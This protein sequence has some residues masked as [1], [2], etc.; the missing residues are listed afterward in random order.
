MIRLNVRIDFAKSLNFT[1]GLFMVFSVLLRLSSAWFWLNEVVRTFISFLINTFLI[2]YGLLYFF[3]I[4]ANN[5]SCLVLFSYILSLSLDIFLVPLIFFHPIYTGTRLLIQLI[6]GFLLL[7]KT[8]RRSNSNVNSLIAFGVDEILVMLVTFFILALGIFQIVPKLATNVYVDSFNH[9]WQSVIL[10]RAPQAYEYYQYLTYHSLEVAIIDDIGVS[11][12]GMPNMQLVLSFLNFIPIIVLYELSN[13]VFERRH[14]KIALFV[15]LVFVFFSG[16]A[17][18]YFMHQQLHHPDWQVNYT[19]EL[20]KEKT[21]SL[22]SYGQLFFITGH[23]PAVSAYAFLMLMISLYFDKVHKERDVLLILFLSSFL[24]IFLHLP[25]YVF[26]SSF[27]S[28]YALLDIDSKNIRRVAICLTGGVV[29][30]ILFLFLSRVSISLIT[31]IALVTMLIIVIFKPVIPFGKHFIDFISNHLPIIANI[32][33]WLLLAA[34]L[35]W[36]T[37]WDSINAPQISDIYYVPLIFYGPLL[38]IKGI[39]SVIGL[40]EAKEPSVRRIFTFFLLLGFSSFIFGKVLSYISAN[41]LILPFWEIR[42]AFF[43]GLT[44]SVIGGFGFLSLLSNFQVNSLLSK[45]VKLT[46]VIAIV[47]AG[48]LS[49]F[50]QYKYS[51][52][53]GERTAMVSQP[54]YEAITYL[55]NE[56]TS[57]PS[58][59]FYASPSCIRIIA[60]SYPSFLPTTRNILLLS[61]IYPDSLANILSSYPS[62]V[63]LRPEEFSSLMKSKSY[64]AYFLSFL[65]PVFNNSAIIVYKIPRL[66]CINDVSNIT[67]ITDGY[68]YATFTALLSSGVAFDVT[69]KYSGSLSLRKIGIISDSQVGFQE[70]PLIRSEIDKSLGKGEVYISGSRRYYLN[71]SLISGEGGTIQVWVNPSRQQ[72]SHIIWIGESNGDGFG[73]EQELHLSTLD[74]GEFAAYF[75]DGSSRI[76][77]KGGKYVPGN[78]YCL[79]FVYRNNGICKLYVN[80]QMV[81]TGSV[82]RVRTDKW[83]NSLVVGGLPNSSYR[84]FVGRIKSLTILQKPLNDFQIFENYLAVNNVTN[85]VSPL[86]L[87]HFRTLIVINFNGY[88]VF[89]NYFLRLE[90]ETVQIESIRSREVTVKLPQCIESQKA[91]NIAGEALMYYCDGYGKPI[92]PFLVLYRSNDYE[93]LYVNVFPLVKLNDKSFII[94]LLVDV[95]QRFFGNYS[96]V[97]SQNSQIHIISKQLV[98]HGKVIVNSTDL[99]LLHINDTTLQTDNSTLLKLDMGPILVS[100]YKYAVIESN[101]VEVSKGE[102]IYLY[103]SISGSF[104]ITFYGTDISVAFLEP[105]RLVQFSTSLLRLT[106]EGLSSFVEAMAKSPHAYVKGM[107]EIETQ[108]VYHP[109]L[110]LRVG[111]TPKKLKINGTVEFRIKYGDGTYIALSDFSWFGDVQRTPPLL[112]WDEMQSFYQNLPWLLVSFLLLLPYLHCVSRRGR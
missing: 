14:H 62:Y 78:W 47:F 87:E 28:I 29:G 103:L 5:F 77:L 100:H 10:Y 85:F 13:S 19:L 8:I 44:T 105:D 75:G 94:R 52:I 88:G 95:V 3:G 36:V 21:Y 110:R 89:A 112:R 61:S 83:I 40:L 55:N 86:N 80:G 9:L 51:T 7:A 91:S 67:L 30:L 50:L 2:G 11:V 96:C 60:L 33:L 18:I 23:V 17:W 59:V 111:I 104:N 38:G 106:S 24:L 15:V 6:I 58:A 98:L 65:S 71:G 12:G 22:T 1:I 48:S 102:G 97:S 108:Y 109:S 46:L 84:A 68:D 45:L 57:N 20:I 31:L 92:L 49:T 79:T 93:I 32:I 63:V 42:M 43:L 53:L 4:K 107:A 74:T 37:N 39:L 69:N 35:S 70:D 82:K 41:F 66:G 26:L 25:E 81:A 27:M 54:E 34:F 56:I 72:T 90:N 101:H 99:L 76:L 73:A 16:F 64:L